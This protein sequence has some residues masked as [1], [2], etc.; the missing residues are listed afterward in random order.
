MFENLNAS[1]APRLQPSR[2]VPHLSRPV[3]PSAPGAGSVE[4]GG[5]GPRVGSSQ[6]LRNLGRAVGARVSDLLRRREP[7]GPGSVGAM[8]VN[9]TAEAQ[10]AGAADEE[11]EDG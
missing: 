8:E 10:L 3:A 1:L 4:P 7:W 11:E 6:H 9:P 5:P 2:S